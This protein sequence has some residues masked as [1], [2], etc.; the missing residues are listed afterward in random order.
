MPVEIVV[1]QVGEAVA[2]IILLHWF[3][4]E[5]DPVRQGE[6]LFEVD[7]DKAV[8]EVE[9][10]CDGAVSRILVP[11][12]SAVVPQQAVALLA[13]TEELAAT[14]PIGSPNAFQGPAALAA[15][16]APLARR[17]AP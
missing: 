1:P 11:A 8:V 6:T 17:A 12:G 4:R 2:E 3:K 7:T 14:Q 13:T 10:F 15:N 5:G 9:A 16:P